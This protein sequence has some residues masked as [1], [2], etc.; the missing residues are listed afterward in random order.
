MKIGFHRHRMAE[1]HLGLRH[2]VRCDQR[3]C[4]AHFTHHVPR[5]KFVGTGQ[6]LDG[7]SDATLLIR[8]ET[9]QVNDIEVPGRGNEQPPIQ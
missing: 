9:G 1:M 3:E 2:P 6:K 4:V 8:N 7:V 5:I